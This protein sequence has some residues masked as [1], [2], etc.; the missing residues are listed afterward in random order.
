MNGVNMM[1]GVDTMNNI[2]FKTKREMYKQMRYEYQEIIDE[3]K[4]KLK[5]LD[6]TRKNWI[7]TIE[8]Y[9]ELINA[10]NN[11]LQKGHNEK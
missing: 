3:L 8:T 10:I 1:N 4:E 11:R 6:I 5:T 2:I 9:Q 7:A